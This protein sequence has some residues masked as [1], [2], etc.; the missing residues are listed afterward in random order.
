MAETDHKPQKYNHE[1]TKLQDSDDQD[2]RKFSGK[3]QPGYRSLTSLMKLNELEFK[4]FIK[5]TEP[6][7]KNLTTKNLNFNQS[8]TD[9]QLGKLAPSYLTSVA[10]NDIAD[11]IKLPKLPLKPATVFDSGSQKLT[12]SSRDPLSSNSRKCPSKNFLRLG[13]ATLIK[14]SEAFVCMNFVT[15]NPAKTC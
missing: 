5:G 7:L 3:D 1:P 9:L 11:R 12:I 15:S 13:P 2:N 8:S 6:N 4:L 10:S 14:L